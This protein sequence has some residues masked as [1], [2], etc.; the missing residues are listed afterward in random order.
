MCT[1]GRTSISTAVPF[2]GAKVDHQVLSPPNAVPHILMVAFPGL[3]GET[4]LCLVGQRHLCVNRRGLL[5][6]TQE[7]NPVL[8]A[9]GIPAELA[10]CAVRISLSAQNT[11]EEIYETA[12]AMTRAAVV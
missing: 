2:D 6:K 1:G 12:L 11:S 4:L 9:M 3:R 8:Q 10:G 5:V 7:D